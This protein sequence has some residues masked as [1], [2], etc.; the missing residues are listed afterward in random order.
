[1][2]FSS[3]SPASPFGRRQGRDD[4]DREMDDGRSNGV[5]GSVGL[6]TPRA[7]GTASKTWSAWMTLI[8]AWGRA[9]PRQGTHVVEQDGTHGGKRKTT[10]MPKNKCHP[11]VGQGNGG[12]VFGCTNGDE[13]GVHRCPISSGFKQSPTPV[14]HPI[15][16]CSIHQRDSDTMRPHCASMIQV[17]L[18]PNTIPGSSMDATTLDKGLLAAWRGQTG[19]PCGMGSQSWVGSAGRLADLV[20]LDSCGVGHAHLEVGLRFPF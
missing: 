18:G 9:Q 7:L 2:P 4:E 20:Q 15:M 12:S 14:A 3:G 8:V 11:V 5:A 1:M 10:P 6:G 19:R 13:T 16:W 17:G